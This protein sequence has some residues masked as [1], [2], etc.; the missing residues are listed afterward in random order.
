MK[1]VLLASESEGFLDRNT[2]LLLQRG[3]QIFTVTS[4]EAALK[5]YTEN[6]L[7][8]IV[9][10]YRLDDILGCALCSQLSSTKHL[11]QT[12]TVLITRNTSNDMDMAT[13]SGAG[14]IL[15]KPVDPNKL[16]EVITGTIDLQAIRCKRVAL[17]VPVVCKKPEL[18]IPCLAHNISNSG[19]LIETDQLAAGTRIKCEFTLPDSMHVDVEGEVVRI[20]T[21]PEGKQ[22]CGVKFI[23]TPLPSLRT[24]MNYVVSVANSAPDSIIPHY[25]SQHCMCS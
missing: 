6:H 16:L 4:G 5:L 23:Q 19:I 10:D 15:L 1:K 12:P 13:N 3:I 8:L 17:N 18:E 20:A 24:I 11:R 14:T 25:P 22:L 21:S 2:E 9:V 7:D